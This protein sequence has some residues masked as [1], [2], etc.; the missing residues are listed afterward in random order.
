[1][2]GKNHQF[3]AEA[4]KENQKTI[5][6]ITFVNGKIDDNSDLNSLFTLPYDLA[7]LGR[8]TSNTMA[9]QARDAG[10][11]AEDTFEEFAYDLQ[12]QSVNNHIDAIYAYL[13]MNCRDFVFTYLAHMFNNIM[14]EVIPPLP[15]KSRYYDEDEAYDNYEYSRNFYTYMNSRELDDVIKNC[16][17]K[18]VFGTST[19]KDLPP[20]YYYQLMNNM[21]T[22]IIIYIDSVI[23]RMVDR[24]F[25]HS[26]GFED[27]M[28]H[29]YGEMNGMKGAKFSQ[30]FKYTFAT[31]I[32]REMV[33]KKL[34]ELYHGLHFIFQTA[35]SMAYVGPNPVY[36]QDIM[37]VQHSV[38]GA[39]YPVIEPHEC[40]GSCGANCQCNN[41]DNSVPK[42]HETE[43]RAK[44][45][46]IPRNK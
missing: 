3:N 46:K 43:K 28:K 12:R 5:K 37:T 11:C 1:M 30:E 27:L 17:D 22:Q 26:R 8:A 35:A 9:V 34:P 6:P 21:Y 33:E 14:G 13:F 45:V 7:L 42:H 41:H 39:N 29:V 19:I 36:Q 44:V 31:S 38:L 24:R 23:R 40:S 10:V 32:I 18:F 15:E 25:M 20:I 4:F 2:Y 16:L